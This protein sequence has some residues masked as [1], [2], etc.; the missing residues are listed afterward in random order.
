MK[1]IFDRYV[2][3][4]VIGLLLLVGLCVKA[5][6]QTRVTACSAT[7][8]TNAVCIEWTA[9]ELNTNGTQ[10]VLPLTYRVERRVG[11]TG[12]W[13]TMAS[14]QTALRH[15]ATDL[16]PNE[17]FFRVYA[18]C[19][20]SGG[21]T[22]VESTPGPT[23][24]KAATNP[25][26]QPGP[27][28]ITTIAVVIGLDHSPVYRLTLTGKKDE[29][30]HDACGYIPVGKTCSG[31]VAFTFRDK[32]FRRVNSSDVKLWVDCGVNVAGPCG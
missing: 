11:T 23:V 20:S 9:P 29:R 27:V 30:Y 32:S 22:C 7:T 13:T 2:G 19:V 8:P 3:R 28:P 17:Y 24:S 6:A 10:I 5:E 18:N 26:I 31:P 12:T 1:S 25:V 15:Y 4:F 21:V 16:P 14:A